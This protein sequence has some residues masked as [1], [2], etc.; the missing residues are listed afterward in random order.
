MIENDLL[1]NAQSVFK[2]NG[3]CVNPLSTKPAKWSKILKQFVDK[4]PINCFSVFDHFVEL[5]LKGLIN[6]FH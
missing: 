2:P 6:L 1:S 3:S 5:A 4:W